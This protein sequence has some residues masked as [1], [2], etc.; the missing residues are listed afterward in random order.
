MRDLFVSPEEVIRRLVLMAQGEIPT[1]ILETKDGALSQFDMAKA[2]EILAKH[3]GLLIERTELHG[4][5]AF[6][7]RVEYGDPDRPNNN[8]TEKPP[9]LSAPDP[10]QQSKTKSS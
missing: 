8:S 9:L 5:M 7:F 4:E 1:K 6:T 3:F 10:K 2:T